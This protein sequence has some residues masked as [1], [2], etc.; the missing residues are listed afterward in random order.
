MN[1]RY[2]HIIPDLTKWPIYQFGPR[3][4]QFVKELNAFTVEKVLEKYADDLEALLEKTAYLER[5]RVK[6]M[7]WKVDPADDKTYWNQITKSVR[8]STKKPDSFDQ[9]KALLERIVNRYN[10]E[11][12][13]NFNIKT[14]NFARKFLTVV[15]K[16]LFSK[17]KV[18]GSWRP[19]GSKAHLLDNLYAT[20]HVEEVRDLF[21]KGT[22]VIVPTHFSNI[23]SI[24]LGYVIDG[25]VGLPAFSFGAGLNLYDTEVV[26]YFMSRLGAYRVDRRKKNPIYLE[27]LKAMASHSLQRNV[28]N[29][30]FPG[31]TRSRDGGIESRLKLGLLGSV[32]ESQRIS[33]QK[34]DT[35]KIFVVPVVLGYHWVLEAN[36]LIEQHLRTHGQERYSR[37]R[38]RTSTLKKVMMFVRTIWRKESEV[39]VSFGEPMDV[40]GNK[41]TREGL[42]VDKFGKEVDIK[43]Y[44][45]YDH[46]V[47]ANAQRENVYTKILGDRILESYYK[48][49]VV[50]SSHLIAYLAFEGLMR[51]Y[52]EDDIYNIFKLPTEEFYLEVKELVPLVE[53][54][55]TVLKAMESESNIRLSPVLIQQSAEEV[56]SNGLHHLGQYHVLKPLKKDRKGDIVSQNFKLLYFYHNR[57]NGYSLD[58]KLTWPILSKAIADPIDI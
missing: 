17:F 29:I 31:G 5:Q 36:P 2:A 35:D 30:F 51:F 42:S 52:E 25:V 47:V 41:V 34:G 18:K 26:G 44:F 1:K 8:D 19:W 20:G 24:L 46:E 28:N 10:E 53:Q 3:R 45:L 7:P 58:S 48:D 37:S 43:D 12:V 38:K 55:I 49:N 22:V 14:F 15:F 57:L 4:S 9:H 23:D 32:V 27:C 21:S 6:T 11:I 13:G 56:L 40:F 39:F 16:R 33:I 54:A 50:M